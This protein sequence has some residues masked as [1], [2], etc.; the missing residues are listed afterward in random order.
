M[1]AGTGPEGVRLV[2]L[3]DAVFCVDCEI[4]SNS[5]HEV[6]TACGSRSLVSLCRLLGGSLRSQEG[7]GKDRTKSAKYNLELTVKIY[8]VAGD[9]LNR[10]IESITQIAEMRGNLQCLHL[11]VE[12]VLENARRGVFKAA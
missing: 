6:C 11:N 7:N 9:D 5:P 2:S 8:E 3:Q 1:N 4:V 10:I 12:S